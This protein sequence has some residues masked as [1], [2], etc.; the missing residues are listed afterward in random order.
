MAEKRNVV[1]LHEAQ[2]REEP[3]NQLYSIEVENERKNILAE[4]EPILDSFVDVFRRA[5]NFTS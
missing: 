3:V 5:K 2:D 1:Q 4:L